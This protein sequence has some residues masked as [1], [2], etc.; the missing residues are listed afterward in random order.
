MLSSASLCYVKVAAVLGMILTVVLD[1]TPSFRRHCALYP[2]PITLVINARSCRPFHVV[3]E[4]LCRC[5]VYLRPHSC[6]R[7]SVQISSLSPFAQ[8]FP[9][10]CADV[11]SVSVRTG[12]RLQGMNVAETRRKTV[13]HDPAD[14]HA[15]SAI[16]HTANPLYKRTDALT[17]FI[18]CFSLWR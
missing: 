18:F 16:S 9:K 5:P 17:A 7:R 11:Q 13:N 12:V 4:G 15:H 2:R 1:T 10:V 3:P 8:L 6:S 14:I